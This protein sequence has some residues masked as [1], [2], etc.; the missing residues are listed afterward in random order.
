MCHQLDARRGGSPDRW[1][2]TEEGKDFSVS[3]DA[4]VLT[5][6]PELNIRLAVAGVGLTMVF[7]G[8]VRDSI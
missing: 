5:T 7:D 3:L 8:S 6:D 4:R 2:F 1:E